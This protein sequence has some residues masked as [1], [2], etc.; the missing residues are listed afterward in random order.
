VYDMA[1]MSSRVAGL[2]A[3]TQQVAFN[4]CYGR[5]AERGRERRETMFRGELLAGNVIC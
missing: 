1:L 2:R 3:R 4:R 5:P